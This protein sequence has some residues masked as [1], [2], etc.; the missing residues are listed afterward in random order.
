MNLKRFTTSFVAVA[1]LMANFLNPALAMAADTGYLYPSSN[2]TYQTWGVEPYYQHHYVVLNDFGNCDYYN[3]YVYNSDAN[4]KESEYL[5]L[6][7]IPDGS[8]IDAIHA[9]P[10]AESPAAAEDIQLFYR[11]KASG[12]TTVT[13]A[14]FSSPI[15]IGTTKLE[16]YGASSQYWYSNQP[17]KTSSSTLEIG[18]YLP[19]NVDEMRVH[20]VGVIVVYTAP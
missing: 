1:A 20:Q 4:E 9:V 19:E 15:N 10:C 18:F 3:D 16:S 14:D 17:V 2:G 7:T 13:E 5:S 8:T 12:Q 6:N 11:L